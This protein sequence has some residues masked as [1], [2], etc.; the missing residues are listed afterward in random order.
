MLSRRPPFKDS[1]SVNQ[2]KSLQVLQ[3]LKLENQIDL[4]SLSLEVDSVLDDVAVNLP[5]WLSIP[6]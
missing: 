2:L 4:P 1:G 6:F 5:Y 3:M